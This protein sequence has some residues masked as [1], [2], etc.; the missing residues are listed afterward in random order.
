MIIRLFQI[1]KE[2]NLQ[3][4]KLIFDISQK[5]ESNLNLTMLDV[6]SGFP[7]TDEDGKETFSQ[8]A[9]AINETLKELFQNNRGLI[10]LLLTEILFL[11][12]KYSDNYRIRKI[13]FFGLYG[14]SCFDY[15][16]SF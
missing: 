9:M 16:F 15:W 7:S 2:L 4:A 12:N 8:M 6:D 14:F 11:F 5:A 3:F 13:F 10:I 1:A